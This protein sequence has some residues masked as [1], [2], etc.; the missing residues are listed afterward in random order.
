MPGCCATASIMNAHA[1]PVSRNTRSLPTRD[2]NSAMYC[3][4]VMIP[5]PAL[6][7][8]NLGGAEVADRLEHIGYMVFPKPRIDPDP[9]RLIHDAIAVGERSVHPEIAI[10]HI[11]LP[12]Q[13]AAEQQTRADGALVEMPHDLVAFERRALAHRQ[14]E[15][16]PGR[17]AVRR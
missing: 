7:L 11:G 4:P 6:P 14:Q 8:S 2:K 1:P 5:V 16:E 12:D 3:A 17:V 9:E 13:I 10:L 15:A